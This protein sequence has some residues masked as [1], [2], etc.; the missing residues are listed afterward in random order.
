MGT[1]LGLIETTADALAAQAGAGVFV[2]NST[3]L[4][5]RTIDPIVVL[6]NALDE[7]GVIQAGVTLSGISSAGAI[8]LTTEGTL[9]IEQNV[10]AATSDDILLE[11]RAD[12]SDIASSASILTAG[13]NLTMLAG[14]N[15]LLTGAASV[16]VS[17]APGT[18]DLE[19]R[20]GNI[21][22][23]SGHLIETFN[24]NIVLRAANDVALGVIDAGTASVGII[25]ENGAI[26]DNKVRTENTP[27]NVIA[28]SLSMISSTGIGLVGVGLDNPIETQVVTLTAQT[29]TDGPINIREFDSLVINTVTEF[30]ANRV[31]TD[32]TTSI[33][34]ST[35]AAQSDVRTA[36]MGDLIIRSV[37]A[38]TLNG[39]LSD[40]FAD[41]ALSASGSGNILVEV[42]AID[43]DI[44]ANAAIRSGSG[45][46]SLLAGRGITL[47][48]TADITVSS[49]SGTID[50]NAA[51]GGITQSADLTAKTAGGNIL[52]HARD[53][54]CLGT[55][56]ARSAGEQSTWGTVAVI[57]STGSI[58]DSKVRAAE[59][60]NIFG[61]NAYLIAAGS[62]GIL[63]AGLANPLETEVLALAA[64]TIQGGDINIAELTGLAVDTVASFSVNRVAADATADTSSTTNGPLRCP[65]LG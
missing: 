65:Y 62:I 12:T 59:A 53:N 15:L 23:A 49:G 37:G 64:Q 7:A 28:G 13:G 9:T 34:D 40:T 20:L 35:V 25:A 38:I 29:T 16:S 45:D 4:A 31:A 11:A 8:I 10:A 14:R 17:A 2:D 54:I 33:S 60:A 52:F 1:N 51:R 42:L 21:D 63:G 22:Q 55:A 18:I 19:A 24:A 57:A 30:S 6:P 56:D 41:T 61:A 32:A 50:L 36:G 58:E 5:L 44:L 43:G 47:A 48:V 27:N 39:G 46:I 3:A 26:T